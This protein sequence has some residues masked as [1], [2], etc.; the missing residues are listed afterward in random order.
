VGRVSEWSEE[1]G[2]GMG[3]EYLSGANGL[4]VY[5]TWW[6]WYG[7]SGKSGGRRG[8]SERQ[9]KGYLRPIE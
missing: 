3:D 4:R 6:E 8:G 7:Q 2:S 9:R 5:L 1:T